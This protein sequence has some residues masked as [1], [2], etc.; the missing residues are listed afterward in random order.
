MGLKVRVDLAACQGYACCM[1]EAPELF[2][3]DDHSGKA[4]L[5]SGNPPDDQRSRALDAARA[6][7]AHAIAVEND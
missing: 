1:M 7:P 4:V 2:D 3:V 6:C 5:L